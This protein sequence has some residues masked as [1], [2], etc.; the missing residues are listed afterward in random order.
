M[1]YSGGGRHPPATGD[2]AGQRGRPLLCDTDHA[3]PPVGA[4]E[5][6]GVAGWGRVALGKGN[7]GRL[8]GAGDDVKTLANRLSH[9]GFN[10]LQN[11]GGNNPANP[12]AINDKN[13]PYVKLFSNNSLSP[14]I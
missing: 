6:I 1:G 11:V 13:L 3:G 8:E 14:P 9:G 2:H 12:T 4:A 7:V 5:Q 10:L